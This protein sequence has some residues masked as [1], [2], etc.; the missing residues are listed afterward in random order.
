MALKVKLLWIKNVLESVACVVFTIYIIYTC[1]SRLCSFKL[2]YHAGY[3]YIF[4]FTLFV[5]YANSC[6]TACS[7]HI[8]L[9]ILYMLYIVWFP[10]ISEFQSN[11]L[12]NMCARII[13]WLYNL[14]LLFKS[15]PSESNDYYFNLN[16]SKLF[17]GC[18]EEFIPHT[19]QRKCVCSESKIQMCQKKNQNFRG[20]QCPIV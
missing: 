18:A 15:R 4:F 20:S 10:I 11:C 13:T 1:I 7:D 16:L 19:L 2:L 3:T 17:M 8:N 9:L 12:S 5:D 6:H 14:F